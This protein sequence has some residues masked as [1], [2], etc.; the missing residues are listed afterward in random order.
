MPTV[1]IDGRKIEVADGQTVIQAADQA[2]IEIPHYCWHPGLPIAGN[3]RMCLVEIEK[4]PKL[5][6][7]C[8]TRVT[9]GMIVHTTSEKTKTAQKAVLEFLLIN[10]PIDCPVCDQ[11][12]ECKLQE[13]YMDY[14]RQRSRVPLPQKVRKKKAKPI[15]PL[16]VLDQERCVL[17][18]RCVRFVDEVTHTSELAFYERGD[19]VELDLAPGKVLDNKYSGNVVDIC[20]VGA[21]TSRDF[22]FRARVWY[23]ERTESVCA[24]CANG[25]NIEIYHREGQIYRFQPRKNLAVN[26]YWMCDEG[27]LSYRALQGE[28]RLT[29]P[30]VRGENAFLRA[31]WGD[32]LL[33]TAGRLDDIAKTKG[34][35]AVGIVVSAQAT[36]EEIFLLR[37]IGARLGATVA[38]ISWSP[39]DASADDFLIKADKNPNTAGLRL[40]GLA[41][42]GAVDGLLAAARAGR[43]A[44]LVLHRVDLTAWRDAALAR[45]ALERVPC[46]VVLDT[47]QR[48][49]AQYADTVL[50]VASAAETDGTFTNH[51]GRVQRIRQ[52][53]V[54]PG[55][56]RPAWRALAELLAA[57]G[58][59]AAAG[60]AAAV[61]AALAAESA[62]FHGLHWAAV[63]DQ[64]RPAASA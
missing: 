28:G 29:H 10:H 15:G 22:R 19:H 53:V 9:D 23:L 36:N 50:P 56:A 5:Q 43:L 12:G 51:A 34:P 16:V 18:S 35:G 27:R 46:L 40:Q 60:D 33:A 7:A 61:F 21:L 1:E 26:Q 20:P 59:P 64:G 42:D 8:N 57:L 63:G 37:R 39:L 24:A 49:A 38:G 30:I 45:E 14:D 32:A 62:P 52:A 31:T 44:A 54:P 4:M 55:E 48:E 13:Y 47:D 2:G 25:C 11:A 58:G 6:I 3:C 41:P 17:C